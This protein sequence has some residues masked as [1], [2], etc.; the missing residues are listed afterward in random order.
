M[1][2]DEILA[3]IS[4]QIA[5]VNEEVLETITAMSKNDMVEVLDGVVDV[6]YTLCWLEYI[7]NIAAQLPN[8]PVMNASQV[9]W[10]DVVEKLLISCRSLLT[11]EVHLEA[12]RRVAENNNSKFTTDYSVAQQW[13][14]GVDFEAVVAETVVEGIAY[15]CIKDANGKIRKKTGFVGVSLD[16]LI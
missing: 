6:Q 12:M 7:C 5:I 16:D 13:V 2:D 1:T 9:G 4:R 8:C 11:C 3:I 10:L 14:D 15:Y